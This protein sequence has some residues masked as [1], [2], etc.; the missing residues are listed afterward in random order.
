MSVSATRL[1]QANQPS[2]PAAQHGGEDEFE[3]IIYHITHDMRAM[4]RAVTVLPSWIEEE[5][6]QARLQ[7]PQSVRDNLDM[8]RV[9]G[10]RA[11]QLMLDLRQY[12]RIGRM[13]DTVAEI[14]LDEAI[15]SASQSASLPQ[16]FNI[17]MRLDVSTVHAS[18]NDLVT[19]FQALISNAV[20]HHDRSQGMID[21]RAVAA[22]DATLISVEDD[23]PG[24]D[25]KF[26]DRVFKLLTTLKSRDECEGSGA[27]L[28]IVEKSMRVLGGRARVA[29]PQHLDGTRVELLFPNR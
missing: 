25:P 19:V 2:E 3:E 29:D 14:R 22:G 26:R 20:K 10:K 18:R 8:L 23:G 13:S 4:L 17:R 5:L 11:D 24:I 9:Q 16:G 27:G 6:D 21:I 12:S 1:D 15:R 28:A 7:V